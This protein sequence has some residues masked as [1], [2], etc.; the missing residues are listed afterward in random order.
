MEVGV[1]IKAA[2]CCK[3]G[4]YFKV[5]KLSR[6]MGAGAEIPPHLAK[7]LLAFVRA[8]THQGGSSLLHLHRL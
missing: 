5:Y 3:V 8:E 7:S 2:V 4:G 6:A 1:Y